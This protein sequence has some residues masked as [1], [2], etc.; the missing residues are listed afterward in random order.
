VPV[1]EQDPFEGITFDESW[2]ASASRSEAPAAHRA[3]IR[4]TTPILFDEPPHTGKR[5]PLKVTGALVALAAVGTGLTMLV[6][7]DRRSSQA[8]APLVSANAPTPAPT[9]TSS[10][11]GFNTETATVGTCL[12]WDPKVGAS[13]TVQVPCSHLHRDEV[14]AVISMRSERTW[15]G[16]QGYSVIADAKCPPAL[17][18]YMGAPAGRPGIWWADI[19][20]QESGWRYGERTMVCT[21]TASDHH[22][23]TGSLRG[24]GSG[25]STTSP[26]AVIDS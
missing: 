18:V 23:I 10:L 6:L 24:V 9:P 22:R 20:P 12:D 8:T 2:V 26:P 14:V 4:T 7:H 11:D 25:T 21:A 19:T 5:K 3:P 15:P 1:D 16:V 13:K 17:Q